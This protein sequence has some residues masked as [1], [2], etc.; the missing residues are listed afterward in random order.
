MSKIKKYEIPVYVEPGATIPVQSEPDAVGWD[1]FCGSIIDVVDGKK[2]TLWDFKG[3]PHESVR[4]FVGL[5]EGKPSIL[6]PPEEDIMLDFGVTFG[7]SREW[8]CE[9]APRSSTANGLII[10]SHERVP[11][12][13]GYRGRPGTRVLNLAKV[14]YPIWLGRKITQVK[15]FCECCGGNGFVRPILV[16][17]DSPDKLSPSIRGTNGHGSTGL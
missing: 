17:V 16:P 1:V 11:I 2:T 15:F 10:I 9:I 4:K 6:L 7:M 8:F 12:D 13:P 5:H 3:E 14:P